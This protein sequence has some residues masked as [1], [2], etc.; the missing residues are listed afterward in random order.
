MTDLKDQLFLSFLVKVAERAPLKQKIAVDSVDQATSIR[1]AKIRRENQ[2]VSFSEFK[3][4][5]GEL[6]E[7]IHRYDT[8]KRKRQ[9]GQPPPGKGRSQK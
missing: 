9:V 5:K 7:L 4:V 2:Y 3:V 8:H 1:R 6:E